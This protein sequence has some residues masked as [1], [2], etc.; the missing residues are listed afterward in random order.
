MPSSRLRTDPFGLCVLE[1]EFRPLPVTPKTVVCPDVIG[2][3]NFEQQVRP[4]LHDLAIKPVRFG[5]RPDGFAVTFK[6]RRDAARFRLFYPG[7]CVT[8]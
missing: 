4:I 1:D 5:P 3:A 7:D 8:A 6:D 2:D